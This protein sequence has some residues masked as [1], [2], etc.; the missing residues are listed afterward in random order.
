MVGEK[1]PRKKPHLDDRLDTA[2]LVAVV[3]FLSIIIF[4]VIMDVLGR[5]FKD[6][7][8]HV[9]TTMFGLVVGGLITML[10]LDGVRNAV[11]RVTGSKDEPAPQ[12]QDEE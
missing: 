5:L 1:R 2:Q 4:L 9:D 6:G 10:G 12:P 3:V 11:N 7:D 8:F